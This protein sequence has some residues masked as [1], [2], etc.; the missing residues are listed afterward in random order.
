M[1]VHNS[2]TIRVHLWNRE[3]ALFCLCPICFMFATLVGC[4][5]GGSAAYPVSGK[6]V[7]ADGSPLTTGGQVIFESIN[8]DK[9]ICHAMGTIAGDGSF[10]VTM[11]NADGVL[12]GKYRCKLRG[13]ADASHSTMENRMPAIAKIHPRFERYDTSELTFEVKPEKNIFEIK[14]EPPR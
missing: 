1:F 5:L 6:V 11:P 10:E 2:L 12:P 13:T 8:D 4:G 9:T 7:F 14:V 3:G